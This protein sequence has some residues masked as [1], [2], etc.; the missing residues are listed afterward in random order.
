MAKAW[1][2]NDAPMKTGLGGRKDYLVSSSHSFNQE[3]GMEP[4]P[5]PSQF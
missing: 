4:D 5:C 2:V 3:K 1:L